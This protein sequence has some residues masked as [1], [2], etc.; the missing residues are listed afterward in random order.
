MISWICYL[1]A[2]CWLLG[3]IPGVHAASA[4]D[5]LPNLPFGVFS[6]FIQQN[7]GEEIS[8]AT[9]LTILFAL[10][11]NPD[12]LN[13]HS[14]QQHPRLQ[15]EK[16]E[17]L[18]GWIKVL[19][20]S[21]QERLH[22]NQESPWAEGELTDNTMAHKLLALSK[23][24]GWDPYDSNGLL[25]HKLKEVSKKEIAPALLLCSESMECQTAVCHGHGI[26]L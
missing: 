12:I 5:P 20:Q 15:G 26:L 7:F 14:R 1:L 17:S 2:F 25:C 21:L 18:S 10:I 19:T 22:N 3:S 13:L 16:R 9:V 4:M 24:L 6:K 11:D 8:L 23:L